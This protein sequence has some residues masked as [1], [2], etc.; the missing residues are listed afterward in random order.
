ME[1]FIYV[2]TL[3]L[4]LSGSI[5]LLISSFGSIRVKTINDCVGDGNSTLLVKNNIIDLGEKE[6]R[7]SLRNVYLNRES[8]FVLSIGYLLSIF[9]SYQVK[10]KMMVLGITVIS[11]FIICIAL[12]CRAHMKA[13]RN[14]KRYQKVSVDDLPI[15]TT[16]YEDYGEVDYEKPKKE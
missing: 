3:S 8:F 15:N 4:Q 16:F 14:L 10:N 5:L 6:V 11:V 1:L 7:N 12:L 9:D 2:A 13:K